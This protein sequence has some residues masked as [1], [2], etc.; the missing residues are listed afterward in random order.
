MHVVSSKY[1]CDMADFRLQFDTEGYPAINPTSLSKEER[2]KQVYQA[3]L[4]HLFTTASKKDLA[5]L[6]PSDL[7]QICALVLDQSLTTSQSNAIP[8]MVNLLQTEVIFYP[9]VLSPVH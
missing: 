8:V 4:K 1:R 2:V 5:G 9:V 6:S 3:H 7:S